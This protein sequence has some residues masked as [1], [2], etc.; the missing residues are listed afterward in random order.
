MT[1]TQK[2]FKQTF[3]FSSTR[4][5]LTIMYHLLLFSPLSLLRRM[6]VVTTISK[7]V[8]TMLVASAAISN[9][10]DEVSN[11]NA[12]SLCKGKTKVAGNGK[13]NAQGMNEFAE[14]GTFEKLGEK[15]AAHA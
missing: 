9:I 1:H 12:I 6:N 10:K 8:I 3:L 5:Y 2:I 7:R 14:T 4:V 13:S 15:Q 11:E